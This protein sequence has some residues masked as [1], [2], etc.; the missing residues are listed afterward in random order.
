[1]RTTVLPLVISL[2][3]Q[4]AMAQESESKAHQQKIRGAIMMANSHI[5]KATEGENEIVIVPVWGFDVDYFFHPRWSVAIQ[6]DVKLQSFEV[7]YEGVELERSYPFA[8][9]LVL[10]YHALRHWS[11]Y[12]GPGYEFESHKNLF[13]MKL[14][15]EYGFEITEDFEIALNLMYENKDGV[16]DGWTFGIAF[17]K[18]LWEKA[19]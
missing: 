1:M 9:T 4:F 16:Y 6:G 15:T 17:N 10:H 14:G 8:S 2:T 7:E 12:A 5:P 13:L 3:T 19:D 11:F 18:K